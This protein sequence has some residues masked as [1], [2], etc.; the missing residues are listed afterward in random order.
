MI[1]LPKGDVKKLGNGEWGKG[2]PLRC[3]VLRRICLKYGLLVAQGLMDVQ[4]EVRMICD[5]W[6]HRSRI[7]GLLMSERC[8]CSD[9]TWICFFMRLDG[10]SRPRGWTLFGPKGSQY[11]QSSMVRKALCRAVVVFWLLRRQGA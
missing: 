2:E 6:W 11:K 10:G 1:Y 7:D 3:F 9:L 8:A 5:F 4:S